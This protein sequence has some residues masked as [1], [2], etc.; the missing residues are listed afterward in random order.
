MIGRRDPSRGGGWSAGPGR[1]VGRVQSCHW[2]KGGSPALPCA[3][4]LAFTMEVIG[5]PGWSAGPATIR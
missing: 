4:R 5:C 3:G 1:L 2:S